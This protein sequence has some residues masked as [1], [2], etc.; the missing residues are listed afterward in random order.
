MFRNLT[1][2]GVIEKQDGCYIELKLLVD[3]V[4]KG[5]QADRVEAEI[6]QNLVRRH[7]AGIEFQECHDDLRQFILQ[8]REK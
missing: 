1:N 2:R 7:I 8:P 3:R 4:C 5:R 6:Q